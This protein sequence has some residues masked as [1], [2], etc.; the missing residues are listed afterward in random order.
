M[1]KSPG[2]YINLEKNKL[3]DDNFSLKLNTPVKRDEPKHLY[4]QSEKIYIEHGENAI[5]GL[6]IIQISPTL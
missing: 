1:L 5:D 2:Y 6:N 4:N 3:N